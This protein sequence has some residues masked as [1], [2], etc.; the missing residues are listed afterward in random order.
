VERCQQEE[1]SIEI[2]HG[3]NGANK[4]ESSTHGLHE[5]LC[6]D[7]SK[8]CGVTAHSRDKISGSTLVELGDREIKHPTDQRFT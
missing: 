7:S 1:E 6:E 4:G 8:E 2:D 5:P 3:G